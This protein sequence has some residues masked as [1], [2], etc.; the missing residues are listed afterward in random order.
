MRHLFKRVSLG[1]VALFQGV[2]D[3]ALP[4]PDLAVAAGTGIGAPNRAVAE[5]EL[6]E[7]AVEAPPAVLAPSAIPLELVALVIVDQERCRDVVREVR[8]RIDGFAVGP[9][10]A[11][12]LAVGGLRL[13]RP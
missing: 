13:D 1:D 3:R 5:S 6:D 11:S 7:V 2:V 9:V 10:G 4:L 12:P 8:R